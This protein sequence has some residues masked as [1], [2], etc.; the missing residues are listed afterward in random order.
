ME[1]FSISRWTLYDVLKSE[2]KSFSRK[3]EADR[4]LF[5]MHCIIYSRYITL[6]KKWFF[7][8]IRK[9]AYPEM[10]TEKSCPTCTD[11]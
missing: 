8:L 5:I 9:N 7:V 2:K 11:N 10:F 1:Q 4:L 6:W 3:R